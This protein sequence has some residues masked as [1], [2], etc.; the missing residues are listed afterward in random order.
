MGNMEGIRATKTT[1]TT[2][3]FGRQ[4]PMWDLG[5]SCFGAEKEG[6]HP[7][8]W[9]DIDRKKV[10]LNIGFIAENLVVCVWGDRPALIKA[11]R[12]FKIENT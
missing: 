12:H 3:V 7:M 2:L 11:S 10:A 5:G 8:G 6:S 1:E 9:R 4:E